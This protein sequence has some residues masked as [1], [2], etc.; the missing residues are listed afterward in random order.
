MACSASIVANLMFDLDAVSVST[1]ERGGSGQLLGE[2]VAT[3]GLVLVV[4]GT[5]RSTRPETV[6]FAV[7]GYIAAAYWFTSSTSFAN[8]A[9]TIARMLS[10]TFAGIAPASV[11]GFIGAE[12]VGGLLAIGL[13]WWLYPRTESGDAPSNPHAQEPPMTTTSTPPGRLRLR[14][15]RRPFGHQP[16]AH[17]AL[18]T[19]RRDRTVGRDPARRAH[20]PRGRRRAGEARSRHLREQPTAHPRHDRLERRRHHPG[21]WRGMP[22][23]ARREVRRLAGADP[24]GQDEATVRAIVADLDARVRDLLVELVPGIELPPS[25]LGEA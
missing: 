12:L 17:R 6:A 13:V 22:L 9:V 24:A 18:R 16:R 21:L 11:P 2:V 23:R 19:W 5:L 8:P 7:G 3:L 25:V 10:D 14:A 4:F 15:Q 20:P 1:H